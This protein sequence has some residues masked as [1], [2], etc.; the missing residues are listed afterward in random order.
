ME[1]GET[2]G[3]RRTRLEVAGGETIG[4]G[5]TRLET[6]GRRRVPVMGV[7]PKSSALENLLPP[8]GQNDRSSAEG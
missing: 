7:A 8:A 5:R 2:I 4:K 3:E 6:A 1:G